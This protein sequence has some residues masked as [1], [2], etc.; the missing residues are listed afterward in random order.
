MVDKSGKILPF[1]SLGKHKRNAFSDANVCLFVFDCLHFNGENLMDK[2]MKERRKIMEQNLTP[3]KNRIMF[4]ESKDVSKSSEL[5]S[6]IM[7]VIR[8]GLEGLVLKDKMSVYE[9]GKR[10]WLKVKKDYLAEGAMADTA[11]LIVLGGYFGTGS[12]GGIMSTFLL[13]VHDPATDTFL[14]VTKCTGLDDQTMNQVNRDLAV[15]KISKDASK[16]PSWLSVSRSLVP[17]FVVKDP[18]K[19]PVWEIMGAEFTQSESHTAGGISIRFPRVS[20]FRDDKDWRTANNLD[21]LKVKFKV[22]CPSVGDF[23]FDGL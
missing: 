16:V 18:K 4:S 8:E 21:R 6:L 5:S 9:P 17:D 19:S 13:G 12:K 15:N 7:S 23:G 2:P 10:H 11:D 3:I 22:F 14:T 1:G 20:R